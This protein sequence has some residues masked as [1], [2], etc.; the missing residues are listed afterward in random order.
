MNVIAAN[1]AFARHIGHNLVNLPGQA[2]TA[3]QDGAW[4]GQKLSDLRSRLDQQQRLQGVPFELALPGGDHKTI[5][6]HGQ[7]ID[8]GRGEPVMVLAIEP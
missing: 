2:M 6:I 1:E 7:R 5:L 4:D 8:T 3:L